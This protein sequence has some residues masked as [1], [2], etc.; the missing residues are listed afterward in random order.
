V[1]KIYIVT[2]LGIGDYITLKPMLLKLKKIYPSSYI[3]IVS[4]KPGISEVLEKKQNNFFDNIIILNKVERLLTFFSCP[5]DLLIDTGFFWGK[6]NVIKSFLHLILFS[7]TNAKK[8]LSNK[9][10]K[11]KK[12]EGKNMVE[13]KLETLKKL[14]IILTK[15]DYKLVPFFK[16]KTK[17]VKDLEEKIRNFYE[18][19]IHLGAKKGYESRLWDNERW[20]KV[21]NFIISRHK[22]RVCVVGGNTDQETTNDVLKKVDAD[23][24]NFVGKLSLFETS[25]L[26]KESKLFISTNSGPMWIAASYGV[27]QISLCGPSHTS[28]YPYNNKAIVLNNIPSRKKCN[29]PCDKQF[30]YYKDVKCID[31]ITVKM[32]TNV[33]SSSLLNYDK[34]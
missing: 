13:I 14:G 17:S 12:Y 3:T 4:Y 11:S 9:N 28:W 34:I 30:C 8:K 32:L 10:L 22:L 31:N 6:N 7:F 5:K 21:I 19:C 24:A 1:K 20:A 27:H 16:F 25:W 23:I 2:A 33:I 29:P 15:S 26:I 18:I